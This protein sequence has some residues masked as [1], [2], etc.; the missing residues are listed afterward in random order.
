MRPQTPHH[1]LTDV[2]QEVNGLMFADH[3]P[4]VAPDRLREIFG[5]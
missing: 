2:E 5:A 3:K 4:K 1:R